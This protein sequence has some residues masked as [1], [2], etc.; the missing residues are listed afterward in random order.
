MSSSNRYISFVTLGCAKNLIDSEKMLGLLGIAGFVL[1]GPDRPADATIIN[2][3]GFIA[4]AR[5]EAF[6]HI[7]EAIAKKKSGYVGT[8]IVTGCLSQF[9]G[10]KLKKKFPQID[11]V[12]GLSQRDNIADIVAQAIN[13]NGKK[14]P[15]FVDKQ[16]FKEVTNDQSRLRLTE[17]PW[18]YLRI[19]EGC[20]RRCGFCTIPVIRGPFRS[21]PMKNILAEAR[22]L[23]TDGAVELNLIG[24]ET[25]RYGTDLGNKAGLA[26]LL[27]QLNKIDGLGW[28]R[29][30]YTHPASL[31]DEIIDAMA[32]C[33][34]VVPYIDLPLQHIND[35][36]LKLMGRNV[37]RAKTEKLLNKL[38]QTIDNL[39]IRTTMIA[40]LPSETDEE[41]AELVDFIRQYRFEMLS[42]FVY[43]A[44]EGTAAAKMAGQVPEAVRQKRFRRLMT[45][46]QKIAFQQG[47]ALIGRVVD[48]LVTGQADQEEIDF[49]A[50]GTRHNWLRGR[51][52]GQGP[53]VDSVCYLAVDRK[54]RIKP[55]NIV[56]AVVDS[57][58]GYDLI[59]SIQ[60]KNQV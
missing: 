36:L 38:R 4:D 32:N 25:S 54:K 35:R 34:K 5:D 19:S 33:D 21:K 43:S 30:L 28:V 53:E 59:C 44:E 7:A 14:V 51:H 42:A 23:A 15:L 1:V 31:S 50:A 49:I 29:L 6:E 55:G 16:Q 9:W 17:K 56:S 26:E 48:C 37:T 8:V 60:T 46:Q 3:C 12:V 2:T 45:I 57:T 40:G 10:P 22:E 41:A 18:S 47:Q 13:A 58:C 20:N 27:R 39:T 52:V 11:A 24:Q